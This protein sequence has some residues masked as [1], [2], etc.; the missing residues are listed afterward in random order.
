MNK[1]TQE[2]AGALQQHSAAM[3][4]SSHSVY[5]TARGAEDLVAHMPGVTKAINEMS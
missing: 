3:S 2:I 1:N 4:E 5:Q